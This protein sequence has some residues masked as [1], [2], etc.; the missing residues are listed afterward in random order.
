MKMF[1]GFSDLEISSV[2][3]LSLLKLIIKFEIDNGENYLSKIEKIFIDEIEDVN[4]KL[5]VDN[6]YNIYK[7]S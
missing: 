5:V 1:A 4:S 2:Q 3:L 7:L 6:L